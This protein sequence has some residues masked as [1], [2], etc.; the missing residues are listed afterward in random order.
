ML[1]I[2]LA[3]GR[4]SVGILFISHS[5]EDNKAA[6]KIRGWLKENGW[7]DV[8]LDLDSEQ[9]IEGAPEQAATARLEE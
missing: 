3:A 2:A 4:A 5:S 1:A 9:A 8:F 6:L 7:G